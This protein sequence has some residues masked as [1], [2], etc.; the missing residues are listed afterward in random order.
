MRGVKVRGG[1]L[2]RRVIAAAD[3]TAVEAAPQMHPPSIHPET[4]LTSSHVVRL[5][6]VSGSN[7]LT[8][9]FA[10]LMSLKNS[11]A[12]PESR[13]LDSQRAQIDVSLPAVMNFVVD[14]VEE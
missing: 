2:A 6:E 13:R 5:D 1:V 12:I 11:A 3:V 9:H 4:L 14:D 7:V 10:L 8:L